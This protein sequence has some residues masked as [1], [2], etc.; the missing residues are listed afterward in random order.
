[1]ID[2]IVAEAESADVKILDL[3]SDADHNRS[4]LSMAGE[5]HA[6]KN[7]MMAVAAKAVELIDMTQH[8]GEHPR[9]GAIDV[10]PFIPIS[11]MTLEECVQLAKEFAQ[12]YS[13]RFKVPVFLYEAAATRPDRV[14]LP[15]VRKGQFE[16]LREQIGKNPEKVPD[17]GANA[18]HPTAGATAV[19]ARQ[20]LI[21]LNINLASNNL[22]LAKSIA[23]QV[24]GRDG[25]L[26]A[27][28]AL[29]FE[30]KERGIVQVSMNMVD[31]KVSPL[32]EAFDL[33]KKLA[34]RQGVEVLESEIVGLVPYEALTDTAQFYLR[35]TKF[36]KDQILER[37]IAES[38]QSDQLATMRLSSF[39]GAI[40]SDKPT[41]GGGSAS[42]YTAT[43]AASL[44]SMVA[45]LT[46]K[47]LEN[48]KDRKFVGD[49]LTE[50]EAIRKR[51]LR[52]VDLDS[53]S[54][55]SLMAAYHLPK[56]TDSD[57]QVRAQKIQS[58]LQEATRIPL[59]TAEA[60]AKTLNAAKH[61]TTRANVNVLSDVKTA[62]FL[63][64][65]ACLGAA[66]NVE[67]NLPGITEYEIRNKITQ[68]LQ[69]ILQQIE[70]DR[71]E[72]LASVTMS[73]LIQAY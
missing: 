45:K 40:T 9:M 17:F 39:A 33:V 63:A 64:H 24:R 2:A 71:T 53:Q 67:I 66:A 68:D 15:D 1:M 6:V 54:F 4:V 26:P 34:E 47:K 42:A 19:G 60:A 23:K 41:V 57:K 18:I 25:G 35:L 44:V 46:V 5:P 29:G 16:G 8:K 61:L 37:K 50:S 13:S 70:R 62:V 59:E 36:S 51:L 52:L 72:A 20:I 11:S 65:A 3:E 32:Y 14:K 49:I 58:Q 69:H 30:L 38:D 28:R 7:A 56:E 27:V 22:E 12:E 43:L 31:Y 10:V 55:V 48:E 21:A 73:T